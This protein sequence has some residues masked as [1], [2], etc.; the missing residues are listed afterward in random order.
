[1]ALNRLI[2]NQEKQSKISEKVTLPK[3]ACVAVKHK[4]VETFKVYH[5]L[6]KTWKHLVL[7]KKNLHQS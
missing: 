7:N 2:E 4:A 3:N 1:M 6:Q 5:K